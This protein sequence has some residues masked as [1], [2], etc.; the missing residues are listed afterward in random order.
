MPKV[1]KVD[2]G[3]LAKH[4]FRIHKEAVLQRLD[5][6]IHKR[7]PDYSRTLVQKL[8]KEGRV[9]VNG[10]PTKPA[11]EINMGDEIE[12]EVPKL[13]EP[14]VVASDI[15]L[16]IIHEDDQLLAINKP[17]DFVVHPAAGHWDD[18]L[19]NAL[20]HHCGTLPASDDIYKPGI[21]HRIDKDTSGVILAAKT[22][23]AHAAMTQQFQDRTIE[24]EYLAIV[25]GEME[26]DEDVIDKD[27][28]RHP[29]DFERM[30]V[31]KKGKGKSATSFYQVQE[32]FRGYTLVLVAPKTGRTHQIRV[33]L[34][35]IGHPCVSDAAYGSGKPV[36]LRDLAGEGV[37][38]ERVPDPNVPILERQA[39]HA[40]RIR[41]LHPGTG[42]RVQY[43]APLADDMS[44]MVELLRDYRSPD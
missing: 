4:T 32:R 38:D 36:Y 29:K 22:A 6:Y 26:L 41:F 44:L 14:Q 1:I 24:K 28:D 21:V 40:Y 27:M 18:T 5:I 7:L 30:A 31:V 37:A 13:I 2:Y 9:T 35:S 19:V 39:L 3:T 15:P 33:H 12:V 11:Y 25:D 34:G 43:E 23:K 20:L 8:I 42:E 16:T 17:P 10:H